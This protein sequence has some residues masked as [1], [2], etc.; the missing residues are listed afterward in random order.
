M[1]YNRLFTRTRGWNGG[2]GVLTV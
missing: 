2:D 1:K